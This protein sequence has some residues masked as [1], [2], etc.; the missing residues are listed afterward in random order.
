MIQTHAVQIARP[1]RAV[2]DFLADPAM[3]GLWS[4]GTFRAVPAADGLIDGRSIQTGG[5]VC[6][7]IRPS[8]EKLLIDY[9][10][11][12]DPDSLSPRIWARVIPGDVLGHGPDASLFCLFALRASDGDATRWA[13]L[14]HLH[15]VEIDLV[16]AHLETGYDHRRDGP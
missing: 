9:L 11:G 2:F 4:M 16:R 13:L 6:V 14:A 7:R 10:V 15:E 3:L 8:V 1:A 5:R 12:P